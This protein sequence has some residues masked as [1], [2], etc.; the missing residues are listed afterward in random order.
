[1]WLRHGNHLSNLNTSQGFS[2]ELTGDDH[3]GGITHK[4]IFYEDANTVFI[5]FIGKEAQDVMDRI[6]QKIALEHR[7]IYV[8][9]IIEDALK[10]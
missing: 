7:V 3:T 9:E 2:L 4:L 8:D 6:T 1:M 5:L 10:G